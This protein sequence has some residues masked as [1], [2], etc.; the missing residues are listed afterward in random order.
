M[1][2]KQTTQIKTKT[3]KQ[4]HKET[5]KQQ[6]KQQQPYNRTRRNGKRGK[7]MGWGKRRTHEKTGKQKTKHNIT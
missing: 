1:F 2:K 6:Q 3:N 5:S 7:S 4:N